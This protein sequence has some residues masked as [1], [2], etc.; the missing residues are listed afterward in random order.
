VRNSRLGQFP[1]RRA[2]THIFTDSDPATYGL[3]LQH[4][5]RRSVRRFNGDE[6]L[7]FID[8]WNEWAEGNHL[9]PDLKW[10]H[11]YLEET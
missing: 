8:A 4:A 10:G 6:R 2:Q 3:W 5:V 11:H 1:R 9:E 7:V